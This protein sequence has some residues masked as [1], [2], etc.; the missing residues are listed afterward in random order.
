MQIGGADFDVNDSFGLK[1]AVIVPLSTDPGQTT[2]VTL[3][4]GFHF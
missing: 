1:A 4:A 2:T 3:G